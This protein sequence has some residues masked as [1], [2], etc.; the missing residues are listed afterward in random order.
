MWKGALRDAS[1]P[2]ITHNTSV[3]EIL[4]GNMQRSNPWLRTHVDRLIQACEA[5]KE[6]GAAPVLSATS[7]PASHLRYLAPHV[8]F[9]R[10][11]VDVFATQDM[12]GKSIEDVELV[13]TQLAALRCSV[14]L[15]VLIGA[16]ETTEQRRALIRRLSNIKPTH[17]DIVSIA[18]RPYIS[19]GVSWQPSYQLTP[20]AIG[21][22]LR[23]CETAVPETTVSV[24]VPGMS[25]WSLLL[26]EGLQDFDVLRPEDHASVDSGSVFVPPTVQEVEIALQSRGMLIAEREWQRERGDRPFSRDETEKSI[27]EWTDQIHLF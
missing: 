20:E 1:L 24:Q 16:G 5:V 13:L 2:R 10:L 26:D 22:C 19:G 25:D 21:N 11:H 27:P 18:L 7:V 9:F 23:L 8:G 4:T 3:V 14:S 17:L 6:K 12:P 15:V